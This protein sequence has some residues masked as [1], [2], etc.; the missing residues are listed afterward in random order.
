MLPEAG[1]ADT[2]RL[3]HTVGSWGSPLVENANQL[4]ALPS[5]HVGWALWVSVLLKRISGGR[6][7]QAVSALHVLVTL[8][9]I[10]AT[11]NPYWL[12]A[13]GAVVV[14][15]G[16][17]MIA[18]VA[19]RDSDRIPASDAFFLHVE[20][21]AAPQ[22]VGG[23]IM[24]D[25]SRA[26]TVPTHELARATI[27][28]KLAER[29]EFRKRLG[30]TTRW[31]RWRWV[32]HPDLDWSW[33]VPVFDLSR[34]G[35]PGGMSALHRLVADLA[36]RQLPRDR[37]LWRFCV[38]TGVEENVAAVVSLAHHSVA[39]GIGMINLMLDLFGSPDLTSALG[40]VKRPGR[41]KQLAGGVLGIA[42]LATDSRPKTQL[43]VS[44]SGAREFGT[45]K[46]DLEWMR[47]LAR[48]RGV[49]VT[50]LLLAG[51]AA[52]LRRVAKGPLPEKMLVSVPLMAAEQRAGM[53]GNVTAAVMVEVPMGELAERDRLAAIAKASSRLRT[54]T[55]AIASRFVQHSVANLMP[56]VFHAWFA[57]TVY[58]GRFFNGTASNMPGA[59]WQVAFADYPLI[60]AFPIIPIAPGTPFVVGVL[61][62]YGSFSMSVATDPAFVDDAEAF[63]KEFRAFLDEIG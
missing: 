7:V 40:E 13:A 38:V 14:V 24:L 10:L 1:F 62:W 33:H 22:H 31:R 11:G 28:A 6:G 30:P 41:L 35:R 3:G 27:T 50:D 17:V 25:T 60:T 2:V 53:A 26:G 29:P 47:Q 34:D 63:L 16:G 43:A 51:T 8:A 19:R 44:G 15:T 61:G 54:G 57:R 42:Q 37:P 4:A 5:L 12:D 20:T 55:R 39:D 46:L 23:L 32:E 18:D 49:R 36:G 45:L 56:P 59:S 48:S 52:A 9:V 21:P 58:G